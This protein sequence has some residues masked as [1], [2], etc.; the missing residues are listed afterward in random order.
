MSGI[1]E[2][3]Q[4]QLSGGALQQIRQGRRTAFNAAT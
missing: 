4:Q 3:V 1:L 2:T